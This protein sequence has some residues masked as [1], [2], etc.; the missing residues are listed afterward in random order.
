[1]I[2]PRGQRFAAASTTLVLAAV[3][4]LDSPWLLAVQAAVFAVGAFAGPSNTP[5]ALAFRTFVRPRI[6]PPSHLEHVEPP[7]FAQLVGLGF[8]ALGL[9]GYVTGITGVAIVAVGAALAAAFLNAAFGYCLGCE[10]YLW[11]QRARVAWR[12]LGESGS[13]LTN[14][15]ED[16]DRDAGRR[17]PST[18]I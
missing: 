12:P 14:R 9:L 15:G 13:A 7:R 3:L 1:M 11:L 5:Y 2:D 6:G 16:Q 17:Q 10:V 18:T 8:A 4:V